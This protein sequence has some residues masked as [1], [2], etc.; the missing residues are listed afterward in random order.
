M[1]LFDLPYGRCSGIGSNEPVIVMDREF[2]LPESH[3]LQGIISGLNVANLGAGSKHGNI[4]VLVGLDLLELHLLPVFDGR[5]GI[6]L[7]ACK[8][9]DDGV[10]EFGLLVKAVAL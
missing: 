4:G 10:V 7:G 6:P 9:T 1:N 8:S 2:E 5:F 3:I